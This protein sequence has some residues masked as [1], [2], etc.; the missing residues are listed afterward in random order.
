MFSWNL[1]RYVHLIHNHFYVKLLLTVLV[2]NKNQPN[3]TI[4]FT[5]IIDADVTNEIVWGGGLKEKLES[6][7][8][9]ITK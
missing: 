3:K 7:T 5:K 1:V 8:R 9:F 6:T 2:Q 4:H